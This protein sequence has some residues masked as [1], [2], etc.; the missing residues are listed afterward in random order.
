M[1]TVFVVI[2]FWSLMCLAGWIKNGSHTD[3]LFEVKGREKAI[4]DLIEA[5]EGELVSLQFNGVIRAVFRAEAR[6]ELYI[7]DNADSLNLTIRVL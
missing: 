5:V 3:L 1:T 6:H 7:L 4:Y 2:I